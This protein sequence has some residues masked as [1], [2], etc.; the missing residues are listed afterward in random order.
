[1]LQEGL[2]FY[3]QSAQDETYKLNPAELT[4]VDAAP[5][6]LLTVLFAA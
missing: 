3:H 4:R 1:M 5:S 2:G 6:V